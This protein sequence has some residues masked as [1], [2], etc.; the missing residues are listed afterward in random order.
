MNEIEKKFNNDM[1]YI[2]TTAKKELGYN[3]SRFIQLVSDKGGLNAAKQLISKEGGT[4]GFEVLWEKKRL[5]LSIEAFVLKPEY[6]ELFSDEEKMTCKERLEKFDFDIKKISNNDSKINFK[7]D[8]LKQFD[9]NKNVLKSNYLLFLEE[10]Y[11][12]ITDRG[13]AFTDAI[14]TANNTL[15][16]FNLYDLVKDEILIKHYK[17]ALINW[18]INKGYTVKNSIQKANGYEKCLLRFKEF[19]E[20]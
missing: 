5:D 6:N 20:S 1:L 8:L 2:Y 14:F 3:A 11:P 18:F 15:I 16:G 7:L 19:I 12:H 10:K 4:Y 17:D 9:R 13:Q